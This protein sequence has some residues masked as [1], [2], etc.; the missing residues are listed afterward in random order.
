MSMS[1]CVR[2]YVALSLGTHLRRVSMQAVRARY[3]S[4]RRKRAS[5]HS[6]Y[7]SRWR[8]V[9][10][11]SRRKGR[12]IGVWILFFGIRLEN[13]VKPRRKTPT[14]LDQVRCNRWNDYYMRKSVKVVMPSSPMRLRA[15]LLCPS[16]VRLQIGWTSFDN[17]TTKLGGSSHQ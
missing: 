14:R 9:R 2:L 3:A 12:S 11:E 10:A 7:W 4:R 16:S 8:L 15:R 13:V 5:F 6:L 17:S 1:S